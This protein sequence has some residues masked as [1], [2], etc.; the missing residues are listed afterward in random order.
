MVFEI[1]SLAATEVPF[2]SSMTNCSSSAACYWELNLNGAWQ[3]TEILQE[4][5]HKNFDGSTGLLG[6]DFL[7]MFRVIDFRSQDIDDDSDGT[8]I[9]SDGKT[10]SACWM[11][12][13]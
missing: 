12:F 3:D 4:R 9:Q 1:K 11:A 10:L 8:L 5:A 13:A 6:L 7:V 2:S